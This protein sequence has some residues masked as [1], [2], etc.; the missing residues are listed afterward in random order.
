MQACVERVGGAH[1]ASGSARR[2]EPPGETVVKAIRLD[3]PYKKARAG[4]VPDARLLASTA[5]AALA[6]YFKR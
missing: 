6:T 5:W 1:A 2:V 4:I 3:H